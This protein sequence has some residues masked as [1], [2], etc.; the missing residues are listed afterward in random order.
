MDCSL[1]TVRTYDP[2]LVGYDEKWTQCYFSAH[3]R[4][5]WMATR[6]L[7]EKI[8]CRVSCMRIQ[9]MLLASTWM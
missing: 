7:V 8:D 3:P 1:Q 9:S 2:V 6:R 4:Q 5:I